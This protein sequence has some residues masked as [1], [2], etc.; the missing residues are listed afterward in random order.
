VILGAVVVDEVGQVADTGLFLVPTAELDIKDDWNVMALRG[1]GS[2]SVALKEQFLPAHRMLSFAAVMSGRAPGIALHDGWLYQAPAWPVFMLALAPAALGAAEGAIDAFAE[3]LP[4][5]KVAYTNGEVQAEM[6]VTHLQ[7]AEA[8]TRIDVARLLLYRCADEI[9]EA[10][11]AGGI[12]EMT[13][14]ARCHMD[15]AF[16]IRQCLEATESLFLAS[17]GSGI[18]DESPLQ[19][20]ARDLHAMS[21]HGAFNLQTNLEMYGRSLLGLPSRTPML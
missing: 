14:R 19:R 1:T 5:R 3:R 17:G 15:C 2:C 16:A 6:P 12:M 21:M 11:E 20:A 4:G 13:A 10:A 7:V 8:R 9:R 18:A